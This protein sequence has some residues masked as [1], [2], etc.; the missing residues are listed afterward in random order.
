MA[1]RLAQERGEQ[2]TRRVGRGSENAG[3]HP[4]VASVMAASRAS[5]FD[6]LRIAALA[7]AER[8]LQPHAGRRGS[9][10]PPWRQLTRNCRLRIGTV[11]KSRAISQPIAARASA[12]RNADRPAPLRSASAK[13]RPARRVYRGRANDLRCF[14][15]GRHLG[16]QLDCRDALPSVADA[17]RRTNKFWAVCRFQPFVLASISISV[18]SDAVVRSL[19]AGCRARSWTTRQIRPR[20]EPAMIELT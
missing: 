19:G 13:A 20:S 14:A 18:S 11:V 6:R 4:A 9:S 5:A 17:P 7:Q 15:V 10:N 8:Q 1:T 12:R 3:L 2:F 16:E